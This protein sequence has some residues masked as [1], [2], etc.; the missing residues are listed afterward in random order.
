M[1]PL[2]LTGYGVKLKIV[3]MRAHSHLQIADGR[4]SF[5][6]KQSSYSFRPRQIPYDSIIIDGHSGYISLQAFHWLSRNK[7]PVFILNYDGTLISSVLPP[8]PVKA[9]LRAAQHEAYKD[10]EK[11]FRIAHELVRAKVQ[12][13]R[14]VLKWLGE[15]YDI[16]KDQRRVNKE[17]LRLSH[18]KTVNDVRIVEGRVA[19]YY[20]QAIQSTVPESFCFQ[21]RIIRSHQY[22]ASDP[23]NLCLNYAYGVIEGYVRRAINIVGLEPAVGFLHEFGRSQTKESL[24]YDLQ[25]PF[26]WLGDVTTIEA[27]ESG[28][29]DLKDFYFTGDDYRYR[30]EVE[31]KKHFLELLKDCF[32]AGAIHKGKSWKWDSI[33][34]NKTQELGR[35]VLGK[36]KKVWFDEPSLQLKRGDGKEIRNHISEATQA[37]ALHCCARTRISKEIIRCIGSLSESRN[38]QRAQRV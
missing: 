16:E 6:Q 18:A 5:S 11:K 24:V 30:I 29:L 37:R 14:D 32:N 33:I 36:S 22:N 4:N 31:A 2:L 34:L 10:P 17:A 38:A 3:N 27:F 21:S 7:I 28:V 9:D 19:Q 13:S 12:R 23:F 1:R 20:W 35:Y 15:R 8:M 25:E 26:R